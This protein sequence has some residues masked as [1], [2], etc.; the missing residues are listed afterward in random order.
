MQEKQEICFETFYKEYFQFFV[1]Y[2]CSKYNT[3]ECDAEDIVS[4][5]FNL[6]WDRWERLTP[7]ENKVLFSWMYFTVSKKYKNES[8]LK[9]KKHISLEEYIESNSEMVENLSVTSDELIEKQE[10]ERFIR[11][12]AAIE[13][14]LKAGDAKLFHMIAVE[15]RSKE[16]I[17]EKFNCTPASVYMRWYRMR[18]RITKIVENVIKSE[19][20]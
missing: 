12:L 7:H 2:C 10:H 13:A 5:A 20:K 16:Y 9:H 4:G 3:N 6:L 19:E 18:K 1:D 14:R 11:Y 8:I 17:A 15:K